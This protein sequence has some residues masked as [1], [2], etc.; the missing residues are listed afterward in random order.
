MYKDY[1]IKK[2]PSICCR[3]PP[4]YKVGCSLIYPVFFLTF[5]L[6][7]LI[8]VASSALDFYIYLCSESRSC[9]TDSAVHYPFFLSSL[10]IEFCDC[11][12][13]FLLLLLLSAWHSPET[14]FRPMGCK[15]Q[16]EPFLRAYW[17]IVYLFSLPLIALLELRC[18]S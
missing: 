18:D 13:F 9:H 8:N 17:H 2:S 7:I 1:Q 3:F 12:L 5:F 6:L 16:Q 15:W 10:A 4:N 11:V 14:N